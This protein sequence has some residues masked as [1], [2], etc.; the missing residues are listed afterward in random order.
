MQR[1]PLAHVAMMAVNIVMGL[2]GGWIGF[3]LIR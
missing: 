1:N 3:S 2:L